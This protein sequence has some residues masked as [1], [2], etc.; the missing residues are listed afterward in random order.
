[1]RRKSSRRVLLTIDDDGFFCDIVKDYF[2]G[3]MEVHSAHTGAEGLVGC[4]QN[5]PDVVLLDQKLPD[6]E[7]HT[8]CPSILK[9]NDQAK[10]IF[11]TAHPSFEGAVRAIRAGAHDYL[12][13][14]VE[15]EELA[16]AVENA[17]KTIALEK[18]AVI[19]GIQK[20]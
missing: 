12:S 8:L 5:K 4:A 14:P 13:K 18:V 20:R 2:Q 16:L 6:M 9:F 1:M 7:G 19:G 17:L 10:I 3:D 11:I 15:L